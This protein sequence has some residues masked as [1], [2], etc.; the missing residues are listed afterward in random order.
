MSNQRITALL[1]VL[2]LVAVVAVGSWVVGS[3]IESPAEA[4]AR[5]APPKPSPILVPVEE[6]V[7][8]SNIVTRGTARFGLP[9]PLAIAP[10]AAPT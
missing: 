4:A 2:A 10:S 3:Q 1:V 9:Q 5:T 7:L 8:S 6:R